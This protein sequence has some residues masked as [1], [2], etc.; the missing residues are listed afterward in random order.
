MSQTGQT[1]PEL[2]FSLNAWPVRLGYRVSA[3]DGPSNCCEGEWPQWRIDPTRYRRT[4]F[5]FSSALSQLAH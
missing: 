2:G 5:V 4:T 1:E 3:T